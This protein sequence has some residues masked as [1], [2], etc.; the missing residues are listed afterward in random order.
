MTDQQE[1]GN[2]KK[3]IIE[4]LTV[5]NEYCMFIE[6]AYDYSKEDILQYIHRIS[7]LMYLK[8]SLIPEYKPEN[9]EAYERYVTEEVWENIFNELRTKFGKDDEFWFIDEV[10]FQ[11]DEITKGSMAEHLT[12]IYQDLKDLV[13]LYN[14]NTADA[15]INAIAECRHLYHTNWGYKTLRVQKNIHHLLY[16]QAI[17][18]D[19]SDLDE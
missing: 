7:P 13:F 18:D 3:Q 17:K 1:A 11:G 14:K 9:P 16:Q 12:D 4:L 10:S 5:A 8:G 6:K 2:H 19:Y 15:I